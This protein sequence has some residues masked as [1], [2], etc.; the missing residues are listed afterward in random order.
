MAHHR[1]PEAGLRVH[2]FVSNLNNGGYVFVEAD[3]PN[4]VFRLSDPFR[5][6]V[7]AW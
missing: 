7:P 4:V 2:A 5:G 1:P 6:S 3:D